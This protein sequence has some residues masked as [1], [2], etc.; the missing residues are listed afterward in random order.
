MII[1][2]RDINP[3]ADHL[4]LGRELLDKL[5]AEID[6]TI[7]YYNDLSDHAATD[8]VKNTIIG[9]IKRLSDIQADYMVRLALL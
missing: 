6:A 8:E 5:V 9:L 1:K 7:E 2:V 3:I 4:H